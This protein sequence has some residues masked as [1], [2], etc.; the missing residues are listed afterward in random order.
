[1]KNSEN[2]FLSILKQH[3]DISNE[4]VSCL[5]SDR[6]ILLYG[7]GNQGL[8]CEE[9]LAD[10]LHFKIEAILRSDEYPKSTNR[11][12][13]LPDYALSEA[14][15]NP[16]EVYVI[17]ALGKE[18]SE[19]VYQKLQEK[20]YQYIYYTK[21]WEPINKALREIVFQKILENQQVVL[22]KSQPYIQLGGGVFF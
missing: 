5:E 9:T 16:A 7:N 1:M 3:E 6:K 22:D 15:Y 18:A 17:I 2:P 13:G 19:I 21:N 11:Y 10:A 20:N 8:V 14:P 4:L 12:S